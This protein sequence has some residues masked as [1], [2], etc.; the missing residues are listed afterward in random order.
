MIKKNFYWYFEKA[1]SKD[2]CEK[3]IKHGQ[4]KQLQMSSIE[5]IA[6]DRK[7]TKKEKKIC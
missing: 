1:L 3:I 4:A 2:T 6:V 7:A 5:D